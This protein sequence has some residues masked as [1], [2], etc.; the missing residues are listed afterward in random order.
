MRLTKRPRFV[1]GS[2]MQGASNEGATHRIPPRVMASSLWLRVGIASAGIALLGVTMAIE[3][4]GNLAGVLTLIGGGAAGAYAAL[5]TAWSLL[6]HAE[7]Q[8]G[9]ERTHGLR[10]LRT[11]AHV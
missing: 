7:A 10:P 8:D 1:K 3:G 5:R 11:T 9:A 6:Q 2:V 4:S